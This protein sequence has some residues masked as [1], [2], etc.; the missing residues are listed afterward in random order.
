MVHLKEVREE[1]L[2]RQSSVSCGLLLRSIEMR[3]LLAVGVIV[4]LFLFSARDSLQWTQQTTLT[5]SQS[6][7]NANATV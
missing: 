5:W 6:R 1:L 2:L 4:C 7:T 3:L